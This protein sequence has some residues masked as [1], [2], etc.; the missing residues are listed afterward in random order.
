MRLKIRSSNFD[1]KVPSCFES[2]ESVSGATLEFIEA[3][4]VIGTASFLRLEA[5]DAFL[6]K[7]NGR[8]A[9]LVH[10]GD[11][12]GNHPSAPD[13]RLHSDDEL[14]NW[15]SSFTKSINSEKIWIRWKSWSPLGSKPGRARITVPATKVSLLPYKQGNG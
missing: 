5:G 15:R 12:G 10:G 13:Q 1:T 14:W 3:N 11:P 7:E 2:E 9:L 4:A 6:A 8:V